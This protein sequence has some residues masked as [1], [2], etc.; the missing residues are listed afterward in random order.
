MLE[1]DETVRQNQLACLP[2]AKSGRAEADLLNSYP[3]L[4]R[5]IERNKTI[6]IDSLALRS[7]LHEDEIRHG[8]SYKHRNVLGT[9]EAL[10]PLPSKGRRTSSKEG[11][12]E[13]KS[14]SLKA[15][16]SNN[17]LMFEL[18]DDDDKRA[19]KRDINVTKLPKTAAH[20]LHYS[21]Q[22]SRSP[23]SSSLVDQNTWF[24]SKGRAISV[25]LDTS[26]AISPRS[27]ISN[28]ENARQS[29]NYTGPVKSKVEVPTGS[30]EPW[31]SGKIETPRL[32]MKEIMAQAS[33]NRISNIS[34]ALSTP[35]ATSSPGG[36]ISQ[37]NRK[38]QQQ[39]QLHPQQMPPVPP[40]HE[41]ES[42]EIR[43][44]LASPW[45][46]TSAG[47]K[48][49][50]KDIFNKPEAMPS[51]SASNTSRR[52][53]SPSMTLRQTISGN[54]RN[55]SASNKPPHIQPSSSQRS[56]S[57]PNIPHRGTPPTSAIP[58]QP[59]PPPHHQPISTPTPP[60]QSIRH[61]PPRAGPSL[62]LPMADILAQ[63]QTE[64]ETIKEAAAKRSLQEIQEEQAFQEWW[65]EESR[66]VRAEEEAARTPGSNEKRGR[67]WGRGWGRAARGRGR[68]R[69]GGGESAERRVSDGVRG[70]VD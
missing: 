64:K 60:I 42:S 20:N 2:F 48:I 22:T 50:L 5:T 70:K 36:K 26:L 49:T 17:D 68:G 55:R 61:L 15:K 9:E 14:P 52:P 28:Q 51:K 41:A 23:N 18:D 54:T 13:S 25:D 31:I 39:Q 45:H 1:L 3:D 11:N 32:G 56:V 44:E 43:T 10:S 57:N 27:Q 66:K 37:R 21:V 8:S 35:T 33:A 65:D 62:Q 46:I 53:S 59:P 58:P 34:S 38:K 29:P 16:T 47:P 69:R 6:K 30:T 40:T 67:G 12:V 24:D 19:Q 63:Q 7:R 4:A